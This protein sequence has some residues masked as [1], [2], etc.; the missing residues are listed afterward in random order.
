MCFK[1]HNRLLHVQLP[2]CCQ[3]NMK[4]RQR[5]RLKKEKTEDRG[6]MFGLV[7]VVQLPE[8]QEIRKKLLLI[9]S[10]VTFKVFFM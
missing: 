7:T 3:N 6:C 4:G 8:Q 9:Q 5:V 10:C 2:M 1:L